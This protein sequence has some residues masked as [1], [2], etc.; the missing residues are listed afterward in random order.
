MGVRGTGGFGAFGE[1][2]CSV[3]NYY[4]GLDRDGRLKTYDEIIKTT[5]A[6]HM[7]E[8]VGSE[9]GFLLPDQFYGEVLHTALEFSIVRPRARV[10]PMT[11]GRM[12][13]P[14]VADGDHTSALLGGIT[15]YWVAEGASRTATR[16]AG[17]GL[18]LSPQSLSGLVYTP[19]EWLADA[20]AVG[21][22]YIREAFGQAIAFTNDDANIE[23]TG[24]GR[25]LGVLNAPATI[26]VSRTSAGEIQYVDLIN[27]FARLMPVAVGNA[28]WIANPETASQL[29]NIPLMGQYNGRLLGLPVFW[30]EKCQALGT[31]G[32]LMLCDFSAYA[33]GDR[34]LEVAV[35]VEEPTAFTTGETAWRITQRVDGQPIPSAPITPLHGSSTLSPFVVLN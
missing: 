29:L 12:F 21:E 9:G 30:S 34:G 27:M 16:P 14:S 22:A 13:I 35:S 28:V 31:K 17:K 8:R 19:N 32:D 33:I 23:G 3:R 18:G 4:S 5:T 1:F 20:G 2:L 15:L 11:G 25:P 24:V 26:A 6:G 10:L 7:T